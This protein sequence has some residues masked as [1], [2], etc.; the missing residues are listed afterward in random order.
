MHTTFILKVLGPERYPKPIDAPEH[1]A[2]IELGLGLELR[3][4]EEDTPVPEFGL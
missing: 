2:I 1:Q 3:F 4:D